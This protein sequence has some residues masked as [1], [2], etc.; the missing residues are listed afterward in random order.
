MKN[1]AKKRLEF[2]DEKMSKI[3]ENQ[4]M[5]TNGGGGYIGS[6]LVDTLLKIRE[7]AIDAMN[8]ENY[9]NFRHDLNRNFYMNENFG[10]C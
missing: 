4:L 3:D 5:N 10:N 9:R 8:D 7:G 2:N 6:D 1:L